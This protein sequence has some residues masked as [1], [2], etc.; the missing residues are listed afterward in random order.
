MDKS[1]TENDGEDEA[2]EDEVD[3]D[4]VSVDKESPL[5]ESI[6]EVCAPGLA[7]RIH[8]II[9]RSIIPQ[10]HKSLTQKVPIPYILRAVPFD[11]PHPHNISI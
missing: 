1:Q 10:L 5:D 2:A 3:K 6:V 7:T 4:G 9:L 8:R 11:L